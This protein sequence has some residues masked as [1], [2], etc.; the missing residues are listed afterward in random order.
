LGNG[1]DVLR[2]I[3]AARKLARYGRFANA[4]DAIDAADQV[5]LLMHL[6]ESQIDEVLAQLEQARLW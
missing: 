2:T 4:E 6:I 1:W 3:R 5:D